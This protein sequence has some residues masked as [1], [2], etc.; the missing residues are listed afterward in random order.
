MISHNKSEKKGK[1]LSTAERI[2]LFYIFSK[3][4]LLLYL[5]SDD[6]LQYNKNNIYIELD[7]NMSF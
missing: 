6:M 2:K 1:K 5:T 7:I 3:E 4:Q